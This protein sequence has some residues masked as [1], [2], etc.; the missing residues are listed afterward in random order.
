MVFDSFAFPFFFLVLF[1]STIFCFEFETKSKYIFGWMWCNNRYLLVVCRP[2]RETNKQIIFLF[3]FD[4]FRFVFLTFYVKMLSSKI[5]E[6]RIEATILLF[7]AP[8]H[9]VILLLLCCFHT[10]KFKSQMKWCCWGNGHEA[11]LSH[12]I[13]KTKKWK[14][15]KMIR[16]CSWQMG[17]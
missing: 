1:K 2:H 15:T 8:I 11:D 7:C 16:I 9:F 13:H 10:K 5:I 4:F 17:E 12:N 14:R 6:L 3:Y